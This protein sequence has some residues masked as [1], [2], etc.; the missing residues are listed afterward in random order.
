MIHKGQIVEKI[1]RKSGHTFTNIATKLR[2]S[3][4]TLYNRFQNPNLSYRCI[5]EIGDI[6]YYDFTIDFPEMRKKMEASGESN[7]ILIKSI[8]RSATLWR[9]EN[10]YA[11]LLE[12]YNKLLAILVKVANQNELQDLKDELLNLIEKDKEE[13]ATQSA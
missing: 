6:I 13:E 7:P 1:V 5:A 8:H 4:N 10:K 9:I 11:S 12:K 3:R 2:I